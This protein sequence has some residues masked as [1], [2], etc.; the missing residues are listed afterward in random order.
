MRQIKHLYKI[1]ITILLS[2]V[3][4]ACQDEKT[5]EKIK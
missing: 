1:I 2:I 5:N 3:L 4:F